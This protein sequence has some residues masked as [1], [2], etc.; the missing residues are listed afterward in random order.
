MSWKCTNPKAIKEELAGA[1]EAMVQ[2]NHKIILRYDKDLPEETRKTTGAKLSEK[3]K[4]SFSVK[5]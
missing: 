4:A 5:S 2:D 3:Q 1:S